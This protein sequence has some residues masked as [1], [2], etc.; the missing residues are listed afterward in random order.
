MIGVDRSDR[1]ELLNAIGQDSQIHETYRYYADPV[2]EETAI[3]SQGWK[4]RLVKL[5]LRAQIN[6]E[7]T[8]RKGR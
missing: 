5:P 6:V 1:T 4:E 7:L 2:D 3:L 8:S